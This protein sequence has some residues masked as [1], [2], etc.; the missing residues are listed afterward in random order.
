MTRA[1]RPLRRADCIDGPRPCPYVSCRHHL[2]IDVSDE[3]GS[4]GSVLMHGVLSDRH[5]DDHADAWIGALA[6]AIRFMPDTCSLD[7]ADRGSHILQEVADIYGVTRQAVSLIEVA[8]LTKKMKPG[9][10]RWEEHVPTSGPGGPAQR[11]IDEAG[12]DGED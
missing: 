8:A 6:E 9:M 5:G 10:R 1:P 4:I 2:A 12:G 7:V 3:T 11:M